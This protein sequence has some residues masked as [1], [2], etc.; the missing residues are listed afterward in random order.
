[1]APPTLRIELHYAVQRTSPVKHPVGL[2]VGVD[3]PYEG[4]AHEEETNVEGAQAEQNLV[5]VEPAVIVVPDRERHPS[6]G[7]LR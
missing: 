7:H 4:V 6:G 2:A 3:P 5:G 1:M